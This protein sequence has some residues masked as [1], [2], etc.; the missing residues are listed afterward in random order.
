MIEER[1][2]ETTGWRWGRVRTIKTAARGAGKA[3]G[4]NGGR[5]GAPV[6]RSRGDSSMSVWKGKGERKERG[7]EYSSKNPGKTTK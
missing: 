6:S 2:A 1:Q 7:E 5:R 3:K 4:G